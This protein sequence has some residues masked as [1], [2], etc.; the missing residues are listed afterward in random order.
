[1]RFAPPTQPREAVEESVEHLQQVR[2]YRPA[3][4]I[5]MTMS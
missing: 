1:M 5:T 2:S 4:I 3:W